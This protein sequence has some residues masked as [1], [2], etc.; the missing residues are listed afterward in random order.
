MAA[1]CKTCEELKA[2]LD[3]L[4]QELEKV[5]AALGAGTEESP[6]TEGKQTENLLHRKR[7]EAE[8]ESLAKF[9]AEN[10]YPVMRVANEGA[11]L[12][13]N[14]AAR[15]LLSGFDCG[16][17]NVPLEAVAAIDSLCD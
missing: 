3:R 14:P 4:Q 6:G 12:Y 9:P 11:I 16:R 8:V 2:Q 10:P 15:T 5:R 13:A 17:D 1:A 7:A